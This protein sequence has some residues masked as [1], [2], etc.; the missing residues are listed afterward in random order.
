MGIPQ[1][2]I[3]R[4]FQ[5]FS[6]L[7]SPDPSR[8]DGYSMRFDD[9]YLASLSYG[10]GLFICHSVVQLLG[11]TIVANSDGKSGSTFTC[12]I[13][14]A[15]ATPV[16]PRKDQDWSS[17]VCPKTVGSCLLWTAFPHTSRLIANVLSKEGVRVE[18]CSN[19]ASFGRLARVMGDLCVI[20]ELEY[21]EEIRALQCALDLKINGFVVL[22]SSAEW[23]RF[24]HKVV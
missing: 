12:T 15:L 21:A 17:S 7:D 1:D 22:C 10:V 11:G 4:L 6:Q 18:L 24:T 19:V 13:P 14:I 9:A 5:M 2:K 8:H 3:P 16:T 23:R 20:A